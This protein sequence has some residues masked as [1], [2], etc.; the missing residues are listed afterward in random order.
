[1]AR[2][3]GAYNEETTRDLVWLIALRMLTKR[4]GY[5]LSVRAAAELV[6]QNRTRHVSPEQALLAS[7]A[8]GDLA[9]PN[10]ILE[11]CGRLA[12]DIESRLLERDATKRGRRSAAS[13]AKRERYERSA[14]AQASPSK[15]PRDLYL[16][17]DDPRFALES[18]VEALERAYWDRGRDLEREIR[19]GLDAAR[20]SNEGLEKAFL[21][22]FARYLDEAYATDEAGLAS[23]DHGFIPH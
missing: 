18:Q 10:S 15:S 8:A 14:A 1:M 23:D 12:D 22:A 17:P 16:K 3:K 20:P 13:A 4:E 6:V 2:P 5:D 11:E 7:T 9:L 19:V 21:A